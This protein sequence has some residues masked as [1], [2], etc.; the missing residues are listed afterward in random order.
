ML[1][2]RLTAPLKT[3]GNFSY[4]I[5]EKRQRRCRPPAAALQ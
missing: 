3:D 5:L 4:D 1:G 2:M